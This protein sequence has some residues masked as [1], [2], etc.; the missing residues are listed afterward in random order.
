MYYLRVYAFI[1][2]S[3]LKAIDP[4]KNCKNLV[5]TCCRSKST[6]TFIIIFKIRFIATQ[7][8]LIAMSVYAGL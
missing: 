7:V 2:D 6:S 1:K 5:K 3:P 8:E 4:K